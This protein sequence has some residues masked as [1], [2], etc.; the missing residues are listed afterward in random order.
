MVDFNLL[1]KIVGNLGSFLLFIAF[2]YSNELILRVLTLV[3]IALMIFYFYFIH[4][5][6]MWINI[7]W[8]S[9]LV[10]S[11]SWGLFRYFYRRRHLVFSELEKRIK[12]LCFNYFSDVEFKIL[13]NLGVLRQFSSGETLINN[14]QNV[15]RL[16]LLVEGELVVTDLHHEDVTLHPGQFAGEMSFLSG[17]A[18]TGTVV[19]NGEGCLCL[20]WMQADLASL[21][22]HEPAL[23]RKLHDCF[24]IDVVRKLKTLS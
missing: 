21:E 17:H 19:V 12:Q 18:A 23:Y 13:L 6:P 2:L 14:Q 16:F 1:V 9:L 20:Y 4:A 15:K 11:T 3:S 24:S 5:H 22:V 10:L 8:R 7:F